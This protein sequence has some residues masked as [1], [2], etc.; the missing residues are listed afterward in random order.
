MYEAADDKGTSKYCR[1][2]MTLQ[3]NLFLP[4][5]DLPETNRPD[6]YHNASVMEL[7]VTTGTRSIT[8]FL[9][10]FEDGQDF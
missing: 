2:S 4:Q 3:L 5:Q 8:S 1:T 10:D 7:E 6:H 9:T